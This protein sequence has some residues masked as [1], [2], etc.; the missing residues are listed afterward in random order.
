LEA[1]I[2]TEVLNSE[3]AQTILHQKFALTK[4]A[5]AL[6]DV[7]FDCQSKPAVYPYYRHL[8]IRSDVAQ[9][10]IEQDYLAKGV[11]IYHSNRFTTQK[12]MDPFI[13]L[14]LSSNHLEVLEKGL[15]IVKDSL[16]TYQ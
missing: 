2:V 10:D 8:P 5:N 16:K 3:V 15:R 9:F 4:Q 14:S 7:I 1:E 12:Q 13:R 11:R 6:F